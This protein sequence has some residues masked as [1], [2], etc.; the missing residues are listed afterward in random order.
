[1]PVVGAVIRH[2]AVASSSSYYIIP[3]LHA[4]PARAVMYPVKRE[5]IIIRMLST[6]A[7]LFDLAYYTKLA[8]HTYI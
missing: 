7:Y 4:H 8:M 5:A 1:M 6:S 2:V 3:V